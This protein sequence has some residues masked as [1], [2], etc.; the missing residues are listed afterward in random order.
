ML[1]T[2]ILRWA[3]PKAGK[4]TV[5]NHA[6]NKLLKNLLSG[7]YYGRFTISGKQKWSTLSTPIASIASHW[8]VD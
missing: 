6:G 4:E 2:R 7:R 5:G 8:T 1:I 3:L